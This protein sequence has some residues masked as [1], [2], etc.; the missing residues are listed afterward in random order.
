MNQKFTFLLIPLFVLILKT[1][2]GQGYIDLI[3]V[4]YNYGLNDDKYDDLSSLGL[5]LQVPVPLPNQDVIL[6]GFIIESSETSRGTTAFGTRNLTFNGGYQKQ[7]KNDKA[8]LFLT[9]HRFNGNE[10]R[11][12]SSYYQLAIASLYTYKKT[13]NGTYQLGFYTNQEFMGRIITPLFGIDW[14]IGPRLRFYGVL[15]ASGS[16]AYLQSKRWFYGLNFI[17]IFQTYQQ[18]Q[19]N[20]Q[21]VQR[22]INQLSLF[23]N[24][25]ITKQ[26]VFETKLGY[27]I[28]SGYRSFQEGDKIGWA[29]NVIKFGDNRQELDRIS[30]DGLVF[31]AGIKFRFDLEPAQKKEG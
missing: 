30:T 18:E 13:D 29:L 21:Y 1:A 3:S 28:G 12:N 6:S 26:I 16:L 4:D 9:I 15:P 8:L 20:N 10:F 11:L 23:S 7:F 27:H 22:V 31:T 5:T 17:G 14:R 24:F 19:L 25:Y 2:T